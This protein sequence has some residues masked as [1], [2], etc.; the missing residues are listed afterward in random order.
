MFSV[1]GDGLTTATTDKTNVSA[2]VATASA[3]GYVGT[4]MEV[5]TTVTTA[6]L[7]GSFKLFHVGVRLGGSV[8]RQGPRAESV[9]FRYRWLGRWRG[10]C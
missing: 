1:R 7:G 3:S 9:L 5:Q 2:F 4:V 6:A 10:C 8:G